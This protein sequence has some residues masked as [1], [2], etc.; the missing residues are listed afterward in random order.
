MTVYQ[1]GQVPDALE[2]AALKDI[3]NSTNGANWNSKTNWPS[4]EQEWSAVQAIG[5]LEWFGVGISN[6]DVNQLSLPGNNLD[7]PIPTSIANLSG[8]QAVNFADN[9]LTGSLTNWISSGNIIVVFLQN[10]E[11]TGPLPAMIM[12]TTLTN[13][14]I[15]GN[16]IL[17]SLPASISNLKSIVNLN[18]SGNQLSGPL[19]ASLGLLSYT[20]SGN[21][22]CGSSIHLA[23]NKFTSLPSEFWNLFESPTIIWLDNNEITDIGTVPNNLTLAGR[24]SLNGNFLSYKDLE[25]AFNYPD[26]LISFQSQRVDPSDIDFTLGQSLELAFEQPSTLVDVLWEKLQSGSWQDISTLDESSAQNIFLRNVSSLSDEGTYRYTVFKSQ[27]EYPYVQSGP[28]EIHVIEK[29]EMQVMNEF[30]FHYKYDSRKRMSHKKVPGA[31]WVYMVYDNRDR[32]VM[33]QDGEQ[34]NNSPAEWTFTKYDEL[35][36]PILTGIYKDASSLDQDDMQGVIDA[37]YV[38]AESNADEWFE[39]RGGTVHG[40]TNLSFPNVSLENDYLTVTY[41]DD[42]E[43]Q[44]QIG[45]TASD[46]NYD[47]NQLTASGNDPAQR[48]EE[49]DRV[50][51]QVTGTKIKNLDANEFL[52]S[53]NYYDDRYRVIQTIAQNN[54]SGLDKVTNVYDFTGEVLRTRT[55]HAV[56]NATTLAVR[57]TRKLSYD[58]A[59]R[60]LQT[61]HQTEYEDE[62][63]M[64]VAD[65]VVL[66]KLEYNELGQLVTKN[67]HGEDESSYKQ[68]VDYRYN[69]RGWLTRINDSDLSIVEGGP[70]DYFGMELG[71][72]ESIGIAA[73]LQHNGNISAIKWSTNQGLGF[74]DS[75]L[76][77]FEPTARAYAFDYDPLN[78]LKKS[79]HF[80]N[81]VGWNAAESFHENIDK[82]D[83]NG[84]IEELSRTGKGGNNM[85]K[86]YYSYSGNRLQKVVDDGNDG[87]GFK[88]GNTTGI[89]YI[90]DDN[91]N[92][93]T[94][95]NKSM[96]TIEYNHLN[97]P[98][99]V[100]KEDGQYV[101]YIY[102][103]AGVKLRQEVYDDEDVLKK[104]TDYLGEFYYENDTLKFINHEEGRIVMTGPGPEYQ[105]T[106]KDHLGNSRITFTTIQQ[107]ESF[108]A[109]MN[110]DRAEE[111]QLDFGAYNSFTN[112]A[113]D[114]TPTGSENDKILILNGGYSGQVGLTKSFSVVPGDVIATEVHAKYLEPTG[115]PSNLVN[116]A[117]ALT[118]AFGLT[119][120]FPGEGATAFEALNSFGSFIAGGGREDE[121]NE[122]RGFINIIVFDKDYN[123]VDAAFR[124]IKASDLPT[125]DTISLKLKIRQAGYAYVFLS[126]ESPTLQQIGFDTYVATQHHSEVIQQD[127]YYPF[128]LTFNSYRREISVENRYLYNQGTAGKKFNTER[129]T[130]LDLN[131]DLTKYRAYDPAIARWWQVDPKVD[132]TYGWTPYNYG[133]NNPILYNDPEGDIPPLIWAILAVAALVLD[134]EE[135]EAPRTYV[136][137]ETI[138]QDQESRDYNRNANDAVKTV[139]NPTN[140][141]RKVVGQ[142]MRNTLNAEKKTTPAAETTKTSREARREVM[143]KE[144]IPTSQQ[145]SSQS[146]NKSG[147]EYTYDVPKEGGGTEKKSV[148]QQT[149]DKSHEDKPHWEAGKVKTD[150][151]GNTRMNN[152]GRPALQNDKSKVEYK[153]EG[154]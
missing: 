142:G 149:M 23:D 44:P 91:G 45:S 116:F 41:Y 21:Q 55:D 18:L 75:G 146:K 81:S 10:N 106:L 122:P 150:E 100:I 136:T 14:N 17:G 117:A 108:V 5:D 67:L 52:W 48:A 151:S 50:Q 86:L 61:E 22:I 3:Y 147:R 7:G 1:T 109:N 63:A 141:V 59:G 9:H 145:P 148:Q 89:D 4:T 94:D 111:E 70:K 25:S 135:A 84:N 78:R 20:C 120:N 152:Y 2:I 133:F 139:V 15:S 51:G 77:I 85:D 49:F 43:F 97:L 58:H 99:K 36:R 112:E 126:N 98:A 34:R 12:N 113:L 102:N 138:Q 19:P 82:Y 30:A 74:N 93:V 143:R 13:L 47:N 40:Y 68:Q 83:L 57:T 123:F 92:M 72:N 118:E 125:T 90:Y 6:G 115:N 114:P 64:N 65:P 128:G 137:P 140:I 37:F 54:K 33:T 62:G 110:T 96:A 101:K 35:N 56:A 11:L 27:E 60:L 132:E 103:A 87:E 134:A 105:Y 46:F 88:D 69:I 129:I 131:I 76:E 124:Q 127:D 29:S 80:E 24:L 79:D 38:A 16:S 53:I 71:Y 107:V 32:L 154:L 130:D 28:I 119:P 31:E 66:A 121:N 42:Y 104:K 8:L 95:K 26:L 73:G 144:G 153:K 39:I